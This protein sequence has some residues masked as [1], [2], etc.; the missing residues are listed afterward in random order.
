ML[1]FTIDIED[2]RKPLAVQVKVYRNVA[3]LRTA[4]TKYDKARGE[5]NVDHSKTLGICHRSH[6]QHDPVVA[7]IRL[8][9]PNIGA[10]VI[11]HEAAHAAVWLW[12]IQNKFSATKVPLDCSNDE[13][14]CWVLGEIVRH[15]TVK[16]REK[17]IY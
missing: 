7:I 16:L 9:P 10:D 17:G 13:W 11:A 12:A 15:T 1:D 2:A 14:F 6:M 8:A 5:T 4:A 3:A